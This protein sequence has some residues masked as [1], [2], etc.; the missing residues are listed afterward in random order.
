M[1][2]LE[3]LRER[4]LRRI[5]EARRD[6][7]VSRSL[8]ERNSRLDLDIYSVNVKPF[9]AHRIRFVYQFLM[10]ILS[11]GCLMRDDVKLTLLV[12]E[13]VRNLPYVLDRSSCRRGKQPTSQR[14]CQLAS[15]LFAGRNAEG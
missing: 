5:S 8:R 4:S 3:S 10:A 13:L 14:M 12:P 15:F 11:G 7:R 1:N 6:R 9:S 2:D